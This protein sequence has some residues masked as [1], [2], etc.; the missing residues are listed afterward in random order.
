MKN[1]YDRP[2]TEIVVVNTCTV[3]DE[4]IGEGSGNEFEAN[5][6]HFSF[7]DEAEV[8]KSPIWDDDEDSSQ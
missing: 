5:R 7:D 2:L 4:I 3:M 6:S 1:N 8:G